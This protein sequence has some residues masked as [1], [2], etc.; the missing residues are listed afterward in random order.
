MSAL[1]AALG[2]IPA[3]WPI[4]F[5][6]IFDFTIL[7]AQ[8]SAK[9][10]DWIVEGYAA[11]PDLD[12][13]LDT[14]E[15]S[16]LTGA[17]EDLLTNTTVLYNHDPNRP[18][19]RVLKAEARP[20]GLWVQVLISKTEA[21]LWEKIREGVL[22]KFSIQGDILEAERVFIE[23]LGR[24][25]RK[26]K[27][28]HLNEASIV[29]VPANSN[30]E[31]L[32]AYIFKAL[33][34][35]DPEVKSK[36]VAEMK[37][38]KA[39]APAVDP[40]A[41]PVAEPVVQKAADPAAPV[42]DP[43]AAPAAPAPVIEPALVPAKLSDEDLSRIVDG[44]VA[45][46]KKA[47][48]PAPAPAA[49][50]AAPKPEEAKKLAYD[51]EKAKSLLSQLAEWAA[52]VEGSEAALKLIE[53]LLAMVPSEEAP[54]PPPMEAAKA[55]FQLQT[56]LFSKEKFDVAKAKA[57]AEEHGFISDKVDE[58]EGGQSIRLRQFDPELCKS[59]S[60]RTIELTE[61]VQA[62]GCLTMTKSIEEPAKTEQKPTTSVEKAL[63]LIGM[64]GEKVDALGDAFSKMGERLASVEHPLASLRK[65][66][67]GDPASP[68][69]KPEVK[70]EDK[71]GR[72]THRA[73]LRS[74]LDRLIPD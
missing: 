24:H 56:L 37:T 65:G 34:A 12:S 50:P 9:T 47:E 41:A 4:P 36:E 18:I 7:K 40:A 15:A 28:L 10:G 32:A 52:G 48:E 3:P 62:V 21:E 63:A 42:V 59:G 68:E 17:A 74:A 5:D 20:A 31:T 46:M 44:V 16:A 26:I 25:G 66:R 61:G 19:G 73:K 35:V 69:L 45:K 22:N 43:S 49:D 1:S 8:A 11:T 57:W 70:Q 30:A 14:I 60:Q 72:A 6:A 13:Q 67:A 2:P 38:P 33:N 27:K 23:K 71:P 51:P 53:E 29:S 55:S 58:P 64:V 54:P 39:A